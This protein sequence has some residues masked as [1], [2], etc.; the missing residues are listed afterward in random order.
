MFH[1]PSTSFRAEG[2]DH[3]HE[4]L[5]ARPDAFSRYV[6]GSGTNMLTL[7]LEADYAAA[8]DDLDASIFI[9]AGDE[10]ANDIA[11][12]AMRVVSRTMLLA[13]NLLLRRYPSLRLKTRVYTDGD[14]HSIIPRVIADGLMF[15]FAEHV[16]KLAPQPVG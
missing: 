14:H 13:E 10:E 8:H 6:L 5:V 7:K 12:S 2:Y 15:V 4:V 3:D 1:E 11:L 16:Q 9:S